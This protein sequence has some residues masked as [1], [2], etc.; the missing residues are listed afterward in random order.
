MRSTSPDTNQQCAQLGILIMLNEIP[1][2]KRNSVQAFETV[3]NDELV[4]IRQA[5]ENSK[6][7]FLIPFVL[8]TPMISLKSIRRK[9]DR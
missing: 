2:R 3:D 9:Q 5:V 6:K 8:S 4:L 1:K 7:V